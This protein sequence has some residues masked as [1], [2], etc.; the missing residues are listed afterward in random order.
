MC[1]EY[2]SGERHMPDGFEPHT[3]LAR[4]YNLREL[5][6]GCRQRVPQVLSILDAALNDEDIIVRMKA[7]DMVMDRGFGKPRQHV[8]MATT[9]SVTKRVFITLPD[10]GRNDARLNGPVIDAETEHGEISPRPTE[11]DT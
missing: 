8:E 9:E 6:V 3:E 1:V 10:N 5:M 11:D 7:A 4:I 2:V